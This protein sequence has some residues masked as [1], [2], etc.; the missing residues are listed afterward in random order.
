MSNKLQ[1]GT[2]IECASKEEMV[3]VSIAL[4]KQDIDNDF[5]YEYEGKK[6]YWVEVK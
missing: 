4:Y 6:G 5:L 2:V 3:E 1:K